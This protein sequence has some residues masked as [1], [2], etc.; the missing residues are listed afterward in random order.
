MI[1][2]V[3]YVLRICAIRKWK[4]IYKFKYNQTIFIVISLQDCVKFS[5]YKQFYNRKTQT[6]ERKFLKS[7]NFYKAS[8]LFEFSAQPVLFFSFTSKNQMFVLCIIYTRLP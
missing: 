7:V 6:D 2:T 8:K 3:N 4:L 1:F 5:G